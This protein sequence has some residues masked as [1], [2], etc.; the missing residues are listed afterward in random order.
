MGW[1]CSSTQCHICKTALSPIAHLR[2]YPRY[3][4]ALY[5]VPYSGNNFVK[6]PLQV[7]TL[8]VLSFPARTLTNILPILKTLHLDPCTVSGNPH[9]SAFLH[10]KTQELSILTISTSSP[11]PIPNRFC[12]HNSPE[13]ALIKVINYQYFI[14]YNG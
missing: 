11:Q 1:L 14:K 12:S 2:F 6:S 5:G 4:T 9:C 13:M 10:S 7:T 3:C 8:S